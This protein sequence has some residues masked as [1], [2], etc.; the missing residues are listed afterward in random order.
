MMPVSNSG[1]RNGVFVL[2]KL[3]DMQFHKPMINA[4]LTEPCDQIRQWGGRW[5]H[6]FACE[7]GITLNCSQS[8]NIEGNYF[9]RLTS[10]PVRNH[11]RFPEG[12][13]EIE[14]IKEITAIKYSQLTMAY[15]VQYSQLILKIKRN[16][17]S[18]TAVLVPLTF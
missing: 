5:E 4:E 7:A 18:Q 16:S 9:L 11:Q 3:L 12:L 14:T 2:K 8:G 13:G 15:V 6:G 10:L 1:I 17:D